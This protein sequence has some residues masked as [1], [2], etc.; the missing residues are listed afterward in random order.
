MKTRDIC[1]CVC[2]SLDCRSRKR[3]ENK[4]KCYLLFVLSDLRQYFVEVLLLM[5]MYEW[6]D[7]YVWFKFIRYLSINQY[8]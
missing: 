8:D 4:A 5:D 3:N 6:M 7:V 1:V 2:I